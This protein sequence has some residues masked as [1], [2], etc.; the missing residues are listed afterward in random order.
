LWSWFFCSFLSFFQ[1]PPFPHHPRPTYPK[2]ACPS[3]KLFRLSKPSNYPLQDSSI[4]PTMP[5]KSPNIDASIS[6]R[7]TTPHRPNNGRSNVYRST[8]LA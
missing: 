8:F 7:P 6:A 3:L 1:R 2:T 5:G 4:K